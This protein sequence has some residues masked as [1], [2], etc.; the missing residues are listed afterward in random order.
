MLF[1]ELGGR[2]VRHKTALTHHHDSV[3]EN[4]GLVGEVGDQDHGRPAVA[5]PLHEVPHDSTRHWI[6]A[7]RE[8]VEEHD[9]RL[10]EERQGDEQT[11]PLAA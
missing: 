2:T 1:H 10:V 5:N 9:L 11:L 8:L 3:A 4:L 6:Q 7:L